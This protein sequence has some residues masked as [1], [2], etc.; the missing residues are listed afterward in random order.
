MYKFRKAIIFSVAM[1]VL[2]LLICVFCYV[3]IGSI[4]HNCYVALGCWFN[5]DY[6]DVFVN[7]LMIFLLSV[8][9]C[10]PAV[11]LFTLCI[12]VPLFYISKRYLLL[13]LFW[14]IC[15]GIFSGIV[16]ILSTYFFERWIGFLNVNFVWPSI[17]LSSI[18]YSSSFWFIY[19]PDKN[20]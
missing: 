14:Y 9:V 11:I 20:V 19:R 1:V 18:A 6:C 4:F 5:F 13:S 7:F 8:V 15:F 3:V 16:I 2:I 17:F 10:F 12:G